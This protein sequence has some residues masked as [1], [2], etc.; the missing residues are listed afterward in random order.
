MASD[1]L[2]AF[3]EKILPYIEKYQQL[4]ANGE[5][6]EY[7]EEEVKLKFINPLLEALGWDVKSEEVKPEKRT[8]RGVTDL[9]LKSKPK[10][11]PDIFYELKSFKENL[12]GHRVVAGKSQSYAMQAINAGRRSPIHA[13]IQGLCY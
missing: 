9:S 7:N 6:S 5:E 13:E 11:N 1:E 10:K 4:V 3:R 8:L 12:D 2:A